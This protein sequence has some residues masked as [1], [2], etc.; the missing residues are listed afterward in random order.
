MS[1]VRAGSR[2]RNNMLLNNYAGKALN[3]M[4][5]CREAAIDFPKTEDMLRRIRE[6]WSEP[7]DAIAHFAMLFVAHSFD[8]DGFTQNWGRNETLDLQDRV[9]LLLPMLSENESTWSPTMRHP[10]LMRAFRMFHLGGCLEIVALKGANVDGIM[11]A[12]VGAR[13]A[14]SRLPEGAVKERFKLMLMRLDILVDYL[15]ECKDW[16]AYTDRCN[17]I[18]NLIGRRRLEPKAGEQGSAA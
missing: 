8:R 9:K 1:F 3:L 14:V 11:T 18:L 4:Y 5:S 12:L 17:S 2:L 10:K 13:L 16:I 6:N 7:A 15:E